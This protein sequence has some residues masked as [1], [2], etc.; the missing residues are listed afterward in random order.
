MSNADAPS[1]PAASS[2]PPGKAGADVGR[3]REDRA[4]AR[5]RRAQ[6]PHDRALR[7]TE[8]E[9]AHVVVETKRGVDRRRVRLVDVRRASRSRTT[10]RRASSPSGAGLECE[11]RRLEA[12]RGGVLVVRRDRAGAL[13]ATGADERRDRRTVE[14]AVWQVGARRQDS[15]HG[16]DVRAR[17]DA[18]SDRDR[19]ETSQGGGD[20][21]VTR[22]KY[23]SVTSSLAG[24]NSTTTGMSARRSSWS[25]P[26][27]AVISQNPS[28]SSTIAGAY[29]T[30][31]DGCCGRHTTVQLYRR[32]RPSLRSH[33]RSRPPHTAHERAG[34]MF[35]E[36]QPAHCWYRSSPSAQP[37]QYGAAARRTAAG[38]DAGRLRLQH[39]HGRCRP[40][41]HHVVEQRA[42]PAVAAQRDLGAG[43]LAADARA[44]Q[45][46]HAAD[47]PLQHLHVEPGVAV[48][49]RAAVGRHRDAA[50]G[51]D[52]AVLDERAALAF[53]AEAERFE[54]ADDLERERVVELGDIDVVGTEPGER[55]ALPRRAPPDVAGG[56][57]RRRDRA[58]PTPA[59]RRTPDRRCRPRRRGSTPASWRRRRPR[60]AVVS[61]SPQPPSDVIA[62]SS[63]W[64]GSATMRDARM[65]ST[66]NGPR[67]QYTAS[68]FTW[69]LLR[70][71]AA[72]AAS[73][74]ARRAVREHV[75]ARH[76]RELGRG[77]QAVADDELV[78]RTRPRRG[79]GALGVHRRAP[80]RD[81]DD[82]A[83]A[84][85]DHR[86]RIEHRRDAVGRQLPRARTHAGTEHHVRREL[87][88][89]AVDLV[90][91]DAGVG[92]RAERA[93]ERDRLRVV[94]FELAGL[95]GVEHAD[96]GD[97]AERMRPSVTAR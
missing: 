37:S 4:R 12:H 74:S 43:D 62:H 59:A 38:R 63:R 85:R 42:R 72:A 75:P 40:E 76:Q 9:R 58:G 54:L 1:P 44:S 84:E 55:E 26:M 30:W 60:A 45:L 92:Q 96:D 6:H 33:E 93:F 53:A 16:G 41:Q 31:N 77:E 78:R 56:D 13:A 8:V 24:W 57:R 89:D 17:P 2:G 90:D 10:T 18:P 73:C 21:R 81:H 52:V 14:P 3:D 50:A 67:P 32:P 23:G 46:L 82:L 7:A 47:D 39:R 36:P 68:G 79:R 70:T 97:V 34:F 19:A 27:I 51:T 83:F 61:T 95:L 29:G 5:E 94:T 20:T 71:V 91:A 49:H 11:P 80:G 66:V 48:R 28:S 87:S 25:Q 69:P 15:S 86:R 64:N 35:T 22:R 88:R 65:S